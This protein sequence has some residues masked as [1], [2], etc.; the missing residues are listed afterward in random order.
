MQATS[1]RLLALT[2]TVA[3]A[4]GL[5]ACGTYDPYGPNNY[6]VS[7]TP[8]AAYPGTYPSQPVAGVEYGR[9]TNV[10][11]IRPATG[12]TTGSNPA[13]TVLGAVVGGALGNQIGSGS[14]RAAATI[15][16]AVGGAVVGNRITGGGAPGTYATSGPVYR[17]T[18]QTD[19]GHM[20]T[21]DVSATGDLR[22][23]D[24]VR[25]E[26]GVIYLA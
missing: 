4:A 2:S 13:G 12:A 18:V 23:G 24:R 1:K 5:A 8:P 6:P 11:L 21:Y 26:N 25:I 14:G 19:Q 9:V 10:S 16:G 7:Q 17:V 22:P 15:L 3:L 20:R